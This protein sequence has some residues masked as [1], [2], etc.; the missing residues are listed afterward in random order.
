MELDLGRGAM[1]TLVRTRTGETAVVIRFG[2]AEFLVWDCGAR[3]GLQG[4]TGATAVVLT[5]SGREV[6]R[7]LRVEVAPRSSLLLVAAP[8]PGDPFPEDLSG[9]AS[10]IVM[11]TPLQGWIRLSTDGIHAW[12]NAER[13]P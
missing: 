7:S 11:A 10:S 9:D 2:L 3:A 12:V 6:T 4:I 5:G 8:L 1:A 13:Y